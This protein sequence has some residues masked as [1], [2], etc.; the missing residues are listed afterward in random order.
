MQIRRRSAII[1]KIIGRP[2][3]CLLLVLLVAVVACASPP[4]ERVSDIAQLIVRAR[5]AGAERW[6]LDALTEAET[7]LGSVREELAQQNQRPAASRR[8]RVARLLLDDAEQQANRALEGAA[9]AVKDA[10]ARAERA[11]EKAG[12]VVE[13]VRSAWREIP[14]GPD[15]ADDRAGLEQD[16]ASLEGLLH[17]A[18]GHFA[19]GSFDEAAA[20]ADAAHERG[21]RIASAAARS[22]DHYVLAAPKQFAVR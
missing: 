18:N 9:I 7:L 1:H 4:D 22:L 12:V 16:L 11:I 2:R 6:A 21:L 8:F 14:R 17:Q 13:T 15:T 10:R 19:A 20:D 3:N 5:D